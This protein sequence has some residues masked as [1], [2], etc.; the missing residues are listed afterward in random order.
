VHTLDRCVYFLVVWCTKIEDF[1]V[2]VLG[3]KSL[4]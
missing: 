3:G 4:I 1:G 2:V